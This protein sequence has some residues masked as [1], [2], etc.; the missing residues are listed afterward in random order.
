[1]S[2]T[3]P[4]RLRPLAPSVVSVSTVVVRLTVLLAA[5]VSVVAAVRVFASGGPGHHEVLTG[6]RQ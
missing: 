6:R 1:M 5:V 4:T 3:T 2:T